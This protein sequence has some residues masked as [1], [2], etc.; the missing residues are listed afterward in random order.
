MLATERRENI[1]EMIESQGRVTVPELVRRYG[2]TE[3]CIRKDL[4]LLASQGRC[5][6]VY[7]GAIEAEPTSERDVISRLTEHTEEKQTMA[8]KALGLIPD[9][10]VVFLDISSTNV[11]LAE[12]LARSDIT[13]TV[14]SNMLDILKALQ[15]CQHI[16]AQGLPGIVD[17]EMGGLLGAQTLAAVSDM[18][19][20]LSFIGARSVS[21]EDDAVTTFEM[22]DGLVKHA[23]MDDSD[24]SYLMAEGG[25]FTATGIYTYGRFSEFTGVVSED[26]LPQERK[27]QID[28]LGVRLI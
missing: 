6:R 19:F 10:S 28:A 14:V 20:N 13:C 15:R 17:P 27:D 8:E 4:R 16:K 12:N 3:D 9:G 23:V 18:H 22:D 5:Q 2:V 11:L 26:T 21:L 7:G 25:K 24:A 1:A